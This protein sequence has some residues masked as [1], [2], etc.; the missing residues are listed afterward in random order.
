[1]NTQVDFQTAK[2]L[3]EKGFKNPSITYYDKENNLETYKLC[4]CQIYSTAWHQMVSSRYLDIDIY[5]A[6]T[7]AEVVMWLYEKHRIWISVFTMDKWIPNGNNKTQIFDYTIK[8]MKIGLIDI[9]KKFEEFNSPIEAYTEA[10]KYT[11]NHLI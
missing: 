3:K 11:L 4:Y 8:Q 2:L 6:P 10:I 1:M 5:S 7:I 9:H